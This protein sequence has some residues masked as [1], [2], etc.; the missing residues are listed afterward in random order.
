M[1]IPVYKVMLVELPLCQNVPN[2]FML[3]ISD[4]GIAGRNCPKMNSTVMAL[5]CLLVYVFMWS[6][7]VLCVSKQFQF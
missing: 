3:K 6:T 7:L 4:D 1:N 5:A 2:T